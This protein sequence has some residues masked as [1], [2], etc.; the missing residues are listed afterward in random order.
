MNSTVPISSPR[1]GRYS[2]LTL[3]AGNNLMSIH[4]HSSITQIRP[5]SP[6]ELFG[7]ESLGCSKAAWT[8]SVRRL[9]KIGLCKAQ[10]ATDS[11]ESAGNRGQRGATIP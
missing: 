10:P 2:G 1:R 6:V 4:H 3:T 5:I 7:V 9:A 8:P 11:F